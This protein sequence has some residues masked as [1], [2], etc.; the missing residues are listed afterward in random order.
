MELYEKD[1]H[2]IM[3]SSL[4]SG[5]AASEVLNYLGLEAT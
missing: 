5:K 1:E 4:G 2:I 3:F